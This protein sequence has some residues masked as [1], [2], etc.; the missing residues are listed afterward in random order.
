MLGLGGTF[1]SGEDFSFEF[2]NTTGSSLEKVTAAGPLRRR[3][4]T[5]LSLHPKLLPKSLPELFVGS[6]DTRSG[7]GRAA[8]RAEDP[9]S[10]SGS[11]P[12]VPDIERKSVSCKTQSLTWQAWPAAGLEA[13][14][15]K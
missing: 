2:D 6:R 13:L 5:M 11:C 12:D 4:V 14:T 9:P 1:G 10:W 8:V 7:H 3:G 15:S